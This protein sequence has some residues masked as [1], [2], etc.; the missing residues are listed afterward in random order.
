M[1]YDCLYK[2]GDFQIMTNPVYAL[3][4]LLA[5]H[6]IADFLLQ[7]RWMANNKSSNNYA[8]GL[9]VLVYTIYLGLVTSFLFLHTSIY[10]CLLFTIVNGLAH[11]LIDFCTSRIT[12][13][14]Y[15]KQDW[16]SFFAYIGLDQLIHHICLGVS[17]LWFFFPK[18]LAI[19]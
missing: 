5:T 11:L 18:M 1:M 8:L 6:W 9:H 15:R 2:Q 14:F 12:S 17:M 13:Y 7:S 4:G 10:I 19:V 16:Y 3:L